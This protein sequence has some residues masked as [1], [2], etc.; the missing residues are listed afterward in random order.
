MLT[1]KIIV[2]ED[3]QDVGM[4]LRDL[5]SKNGYSVMLLNDGSS[6]IREIEKNKPDLMILDLGLPT[7]GGE[8]VCAEVKKLYPDVPVIILTA[9]GGTSNVVKGLRMGAD[10]YIAKPFEA[11]ELLARMQSALRAYHI[12]AEVLK[13]GDLELNNQTL[14]VSRAGKKIT[15]TAQEFK[16]LEFL[17]YNKG[18]VLSRDLILN[19][20]WNNWSEIETRVID[21]YIG[22]LRKKVDAGFKKKLIQSVRGFGYAIRE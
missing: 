1:N 4:Y 19:R 6:A 18:R 21:V 10:D 17:M 5:L 12:G 7:I 20:I 8:T 15:L 2:V 14:E 13:V 11:E 16:L 3:D 9:K 22:Y